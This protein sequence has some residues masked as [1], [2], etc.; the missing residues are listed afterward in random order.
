MEQSLLLLALLLLIIIII[1]SSAEIKLLDMT[2]ADNN[3]KQIIDAPP[4]SITSNPQQG[5]VEDPRVLAGG[6]VKGPTP[7][8]LAPCS[9]LTISS[10]LEQQP[11]PTA[12][13]P[14]AVAANVPVV[15]VVG[16]PLMEAPPPSAP[17]NMTATNAV[18][19]PEEKRWKR[20]PPTEFDSRKLFVGG[21]PTNGKL[22]IFIALMDAAA[23][24]FVVLVVK[25]SLNL[26]KK[27]TTFHSYS[28]QSPPLSL[29]SLPHLLA[30]M[31][32]HNTNQ[33]PHSSVNDEQFLY[34]F[35]QFGEVIDSVVMVDRSTKR[36][37]GF[38][39]VTFASQVC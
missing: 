21:L 8:P 25:E 13:T 36:S 37:R 34:F 18:P 23:L 35:E 14:T 15:A 16:G 3:V 12:A 4:S 24:I 7:P 20:T 30:I 2:A 32:G 28:Q 38:G 26:R 11:A 31:H 5:M 6:S 29:N 22:L 1:L 9:P 27:V 10:A 39:F 17:N 19:S 33:Q